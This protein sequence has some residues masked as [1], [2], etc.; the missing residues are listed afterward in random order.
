MWVG[1]RKSLELFAIL[2]VGIIAAICPAIANVSLGDAF[3]VFFAV[4]LH[5]VVT[6]LPAVPLVTQIVAIILSVAKIIQRHATFVATSELGEVAFGID[7]VRCL[8]GSITLA[9]IQLGITH[10]CFGN[11]SSSFLKKKLQ[12]FNF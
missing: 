12:M 9:T 3:I 6:E 1:T 11:A 7:T 4:K 2:F 5:G 10:P 8:V